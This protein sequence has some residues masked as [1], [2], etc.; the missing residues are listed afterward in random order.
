MSLF[1]KSAS[2]KPQPPSTGN[3]DLPDGH[4]DDDS[5][6]YVR[7]EHRPYYVAD[8]DAEQDAIRDEKW[9]VVV[10]KQSQWPHVRE[11]MIGKYHTP[12]LIRR[13]D[14]QIERGAQNTWI[15]NDLDH[16]SPA[17]SE[18]RRL[19][20]H[21]VRLHRAR[22]EYERRRE[23]DER[24]RHWTRSHTCAACTLVRPDVREYAP[25][26]L[27]PTLAARGTGKVQLCDSCTLVLPGVAADRARADVLDDGRTRDQ[28]CAALLDRLTS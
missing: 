1:T 3:P 8:T 5:L 25:R 28:A 19:I 20:V 4:D 13:T 27:L 18:E 17:T 6:F 14:E 7:P 9:R 22:Q 2:D 21:G 16:D 12:G 15:V 23:A 10:R 11:R 26:A 24:H